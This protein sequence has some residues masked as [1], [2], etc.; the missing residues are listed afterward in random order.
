MDGFFNEKG[1]ASRREI[2]SEVHWESCDMILSVNQVTQDII[3]Y[4][5]S[6]CVYKLSRHGLQPIEISKFKKNLFKT[7]N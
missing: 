5:L 1:S 7:D 4:H 6:T 2:T 3:L